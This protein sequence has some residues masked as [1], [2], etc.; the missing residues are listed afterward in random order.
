MFGH[1]YL[2]NALICFS[3]YGY[4]L[5]SRSQVKQKNKMSENELIKQFKAKFKKHYDYNLAKD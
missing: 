1:D 4:D 2:D 5:R 3:K